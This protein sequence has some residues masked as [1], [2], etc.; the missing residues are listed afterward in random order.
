MTMTKAVVP[1]WKFLK[2]LQTAVAA[3][4]MIMTK[5]VVPFWKFFNEI[6][7]AAII[8]FMAM[9]KGDIPFCNFSKFLGFR[10]YYNFFRNVYGF[11]F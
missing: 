7:T 6:Q 8:L 9:T 5:A 11:D 2:E 1:F 4:V 3:L 10:A